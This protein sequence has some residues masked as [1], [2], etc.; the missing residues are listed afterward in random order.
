M[1]TFNYKAKDRQGNTVTGVIDADSA[2]QAA[3][4]IREQGH[5]P[6]DIRPARGY[7]PQTQEAGSWFARKFI[8]PI[9][10]G[11]NLRSLSLFYRQ[12]HTLLDAGMTLSEALGSVGSRTR[13]KLG[14]LIGRGFE[15]ATRLRWRFFR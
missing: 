5:M 12:L 2:S 4:Q 11:V 9:W 6:M 13:G 7:V 14:R 1:P 10:T 15:T 8:H 3:G